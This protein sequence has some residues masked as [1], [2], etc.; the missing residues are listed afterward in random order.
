MSTNAT[1]HAS[2]WDVQRERL[3]AYLDR[4]LPAAEHAALERHVA[5][6]ARCTAELAELRQV[7]TLL[8]ALP[9]PRVPRSFALPETDVSRQISARAASTP[10][11]GVVRAPRWTAVAEWAGGLAA[12]AGIVLLLGA[13]LGGLT[14]HIASNAGASMSAYQRVPGGSGSGYG[15]NRAQPAPTGSASYDT[16]QRGTPARVASPSTVVATSAPTVAPT[17]TQPGAGARSLQ[18]HPEEG[19]P[20]LVDTPVVGGGL[21]AAGTV[22]FVLARRRRRSG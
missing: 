2:D 10:R 13:A 7:V 22:V 20:G 16:S 9:T 21:L 11:T 8:R 12:A 5:G 1:E 6:C 3:S 18:T 17:S 4:Q 15:A 19:P 14:G